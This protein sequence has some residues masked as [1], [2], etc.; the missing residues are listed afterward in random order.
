MRSMRLGSED[1]DT[2]YNTIV[3]RGQ[4]WKDVLGGK[5]IPDVIVASR[6]HVLRSDFA[7]YDFHSAASLLRFTANTIGHFEEL[8]LGLQLSKVAFLDAILALFPALVPVCYHYLAAYPSLHVRNRDSELVSSLLSAMGT[9]CTCH[10]CEVSTAFPSRCPL[11]LIQGEIDTAV[12]C[13]CSVR[14]R[15]TSMRRIAS[16]TM[17]FQAMQMHACGDSPALK[18]TSLHLTSNLSQSLRKSS[19]LGDA[20]TPPRVTAPLAPCGMMN[21][22][23][24][25]QRWDCP[26]SVTAL[27]EPHM[28]WEKEGGCLLPDRFCVASMTWLFLHV[29][30]D[31]SF[32]GT[33]LQGVYGGCMSPVCMPQRA[34]LCRN[35][36][37]YE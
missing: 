10:E 36:R 2:N 3:L 26:V 32:A 31:Q 13:R 27:L 34:R 11:Y 25:S 6:Q 8:Q 37:C 21:V 14:L 17:H 1:F 22:S 16:C 23:C 28:S 35:P 20:T 24:G 4:S 12:P 29:F 19:V 7:A 9:D 30:I 5:L 33:S 18:D 15:A